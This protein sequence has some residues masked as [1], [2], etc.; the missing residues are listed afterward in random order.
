MATKLYCKQFQNSNVNLSGTYLYASLVPSVLA[1]ISLVT[2][3][4]N[5]TTQQTAVAGGSVV[6]WI[7]PP[8]AA[9]VTISGTITYNTW[10]KTSS[11]TGA[12]K[13]IGR[14]YKWSAGTVTQISTKTS[15]LTQSTAI[16]HDSFTDTAP[17]STAFARGDR[18]VIKW[19]VSSTSATGTETLDYGGKTATFDGDT[20]VQF[21]ETFTFQREPEAIQEAPFN[22]VGS[23]TTATCTFPGVCAAGN[24][25][26]A[27]AIWDNTANTAAITDGGDLFTERLG[28]LTWNTT[29]KQAGWDCLSIVGGSALTLTI[30]TSGAVTSILGVAAWEYFGLD[31][32]DTGSSATGTSTTANSGSATTAYANEIII[33]MQNNGGAGSAVPTGNLISRDASGIGMSDYVVNATGSQAAT[34]S[35]SPSQV[36]TSQFMSYKFGFHSATINASMP[37]F[38]ATQTKQAGKAQPA[39]MSPFV[40]T[41]VRTTSAVVTGSMATFAAAPAKQGG[42]AVA[43]SMSAF[44]ATAAKRAGKAINATQA[45]FSATQA[46]ASSIALSAA[47]AVFGAVI[48]RLTTVAESAALPNFTATP[49]K[50][51]N[52]PTAAAMPTFAGTAA[53]RQGIAIAAATASFAGSTARQIGVAQ[54]GSMATFAGVIVRLTKI[55]GPAAMALFAGNP[56]RTHSAS[57][58]AAM[59]SFAGSTAKSTN[60]SESAAMAAFTGATAR[61][62]SK[63]ITA[64]MSTMAATPARTAGIALAAAMA[65]FAVTTVRLTSAAI[66]STMASFAGISTKSTGI[67]TAAAMG[68]FQGTTGRKSSMSVGASMASFAGSV[69]RGVSVT[70]AASMAL[71]NATAVAFKAA[72]TFFV[73]VN[74]AMATFAVATLRAVGAAVNASTQP[75]AGAT[76]RKTSIARTAALPTFA[77][78][79][80]RSTSKLTQATM[81][82]F[83][84][85]G[86][87]VLIGG[88]VFTVSV[89]AAM[90]VFAA[91]IQRTTQKKE[92]A[93]MR[94]MSGRPGRG[95]VFSV[96]AAMTYFGGVTSTVNVIVEYLVSIAVVIAPAIFAF[97][98]AII[99]ELQSIATG[100]IPKLNAAG[101]AVQ[102]FEKL[103]VIADG[104]IPALV[105]GGGQMQGSTLTAFVLNDQFVCVFGLSRALQAPGDTPDWVDDAAGTAQIY[106]SLG[107]SVAGPLTFAFVTGPIVMP[108]GSTSPDGNYLAPLP[109]SFNPTPGCDYLCKITLTSTSGGVYHIERTTQV[110]VRTQ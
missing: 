101:M 88:R 63:A 53:K 39:A 52:L 49:A 25:I 4:I 61:R 73:T 104:C 6:S 94:P 14:V 62:T 93:T 57:T 59:G 10:A 34:A 82:V 81:A 36:W 92:A 8:L 42:K 30:T 15:T 108:N 98:A 60:V 17:T 87:A 45:L 51:S 79:T 105:A 78:T 35:V 33:A 32:Y 71:F 107:N 20:W 103:Q 27:T 74:A 46:R 41:Q 7:S 29:Q 24:A 96:E 90:S 5:G 99:G 13:T 95:F 72:N 3:K 21:T 28:D 1:S 55:A 64:V 86:V 37:T 22:F 77:G 19:W 102:E 47:M 67:S 91:A 66:A 12:P 31:A 26:V 84:G 100:T 58:S 23:G 56:S 97:G 44:A 11:T 50:Q 83:G 85:V 18:I 76:S 75:M 106:D 9:A 109:S 43:A 54:S 89:N 48:K 40:A 65:S 68:S 110:Q 16:Q 38:A 70:A 69:A 80:A 2:N